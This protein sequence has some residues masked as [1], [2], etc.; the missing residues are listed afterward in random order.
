MTSGRL[1]AAV[2]SSSV[3]STWTLEIV[4]LQSVNFLGVS[5]L[6]C[7]LC[8]RELVGQTPGSQLH[9]AGLAN[10]TV[11]RPLKRIGLLKL[12]DSYPTLADAV[13]TLANERPCWPA[14]QAER[15]W[16]S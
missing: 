14:R 13:A 2:W 15:E 7:L 4:D 6:S 10:R 12:V 16:P 9:L 11:A 8:I 5:G 1:L 3:G